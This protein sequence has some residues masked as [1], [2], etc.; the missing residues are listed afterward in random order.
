MRETNGAAGAG[1]LDPSRA[2]PVIVCPECGGLE[3]GGYLGER[4]GEVVVANRAHFADERGF[5]HCAEC[6]AVWGRTYRLPEYSGPTPPPGVHGDAVHRAQTWFSPAQSPDVATWRRLKQQH[7]RASRVPPATHGR[8]AARVYD[9]EALCA[10][11]EL[12]FDVTRAVTFH[13]TV[14]SERAD[15]RE[16][17]GR[18]IVQGRARTVRAEACVVATIILVLERFRIER[19]GA[20]ATLFDAFS[21]KRGPRRVLRAEYAAAYRGLSEW[22]ATHLWRDGRA[23]S[24]QNGSAKHD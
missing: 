23:T 13:L 12:S 3:P 7:V 16:V 22:Y 9:A 24:T 4:S 14:L 18:Y 8:M 6:G 19:Q 1:G 17:I 5:L 2:T 15:T 10:A 11:L 21:F 20:L